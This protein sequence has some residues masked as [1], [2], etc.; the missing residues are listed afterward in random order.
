[1]NSI[2]EPTN[3]EQ[4][5]T[6]TDMTSTT[7]MTSTTIDAA[8]SMQTRSAQ[9]YAENQLLQA[10]VDGLWVE[11][12]FDGTDGEWLAL[13]QAQSL[14]GSL[15]RDLSE[16]WLLTEQP[17]SRLWR[18]QHDEGHALVMLMQPGITQAW[19]K[20]PG[21]QVFHQQSS[22][23]PSWCALAPRQ[24]MLEIFKGQN[25]PSEETLEAGELGLGEQVFLEALRVSEEQTALSVDHRVDTR[26]LLERS[27]AE[28]FTIMEQWASLLDRPYHPTAKA[29]QGLSNDEYHAY[30]AE[31]A[32]PIALRWV[33]IPRGQMTT[34]AGVDDSDMGP[35]AWMADATTQ[36]ALKAALEQQGLAD[37]HIA[38][39][40]HPWQHQ[41]ALPKW[42]D[43][44]FK[45]GQ[46]VTLEVESSPWL[47]TSS[48]RSMAPM[49]SSAHFLKLPMA[50]HSLGASRYL[51]AVKMLNGD[52]S[53]SLLHQAREKDERLA[54]SLYLCDEGKWWA[55]MPQEATL[56][57]EAPRHL[58]A[59]VRSYPEQLLT[60]STYRLIPMAAL[61]TP[62]P[63]GGHHFFDDWL[64][65][66]G[67]EA[68][69]ETVTGLFAELCQCFFELN[70]RM[71]RLGMLAEVHGQNAVLVWKDG[72]C[73]G[74]L[75]RDH[76]SLRITVPR[77]EEHGMQDPCYCIKPGHSNTLYHDDPEALL[78]WMQTLAIQVN[79]RAIIDTVAGHYAIP[80]TTLWATMA[81]VIDSQ[82]EQIPFSAE[83]RQLLRSQLLE[84][85]DWPYKLLIAP[86]IERAGGPGS[87]PFGT[88]RTTN[89]FQ[90][91]AATTPMATPSVTPQATAD[92]VDT[93]TA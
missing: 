73:D 15:P 39:P 7:N 90:R 77:L 71:F 32:Q 59:M 38:I 85:E 69:F 78:F 60:D 58:S 84:A 16:R 74:L 22:G 37:S 56:F 30:M 31:F 54:E 86:I 76:D 82:I 41:H 6:A 83:D 26:R 61:G 40:V 10:L 65:H 87:M 46:C 35:A 63:E 57:D 88:G 89:P 36:G 66:R 72:Q 8:E 24:L 23:E 9:Q 28:F 68:S 48:L 5:N 34:G 67:L 47:A 1:M 33:A 75:L 79:L 12:F 2:T 18:W 42:L 21:S 13:E 29:K 17:Q 44:A 92:A 70:L 55:F 80:V 19:E 27:S 20:V 93:A 14:L 91:V 52:L 43:E 11:G 3:A 62:L 64:A 25:V 45:A 4:M 53:A 50:I 81:Q 51:P 49:D